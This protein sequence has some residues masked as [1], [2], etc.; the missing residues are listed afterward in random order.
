MQ[1]AGV[2]HALPTCERP[3]AH[4]CNALLGWGW[5]CKMQKIDQG[6]NVW[7]QP[8]SVRLVVG[9]LRP[10]AKSDGWFSLKRA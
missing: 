6:M 7:D 9:M 4:V 1:L 10:A 8:Q 3:M 5:G 2:L